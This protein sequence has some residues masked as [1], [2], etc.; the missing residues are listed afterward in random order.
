MLKFQ[1]IQCS[2][3]TIAAQTTTN[4]RIFKKDD[5]NSWKANNNVSNIYSIWVDGTWGEVWQSTASIYGGSL[6]VQIQSF[7][8][9]SLTIS[10][11]LYIIYI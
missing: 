1:T 11:V 5:F 10:P 8:D 4:V 9:G 3:I 7:Y 2:S 6:Y